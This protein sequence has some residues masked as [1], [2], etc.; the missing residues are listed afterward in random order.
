MKVAYTVRLDKG[1]ITYMADYK[2]AECGWVNNDRSFFY[3]REGESNLYCSLH[4]NKE[5]C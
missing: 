2:C 5:N 3:E 4:V 1:K